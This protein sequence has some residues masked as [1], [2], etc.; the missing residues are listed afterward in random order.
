MPAPPGKA[1]PLPSLESK[2]LKH[3]LLRFALFGIACILPL[4]AIAWQVGDDSG[5]TEVHPM[6]QDLL[7]AVKDRPDHS[8]SWRMLGKIYCQQG[9]HEKAVEAINRA[10]NLMPDNAAAHFDLGELSAKLNRLEDRDFHYRK[11]LE[12]AP[13]TEY[14]QRVTDSGFETWLSTVNRPPTDWQVDDMPFDFG[15]SFVTGEPSDSV[16]QVSYE[17]Q[18]FDGADDLQRRLEQL[19]AS[20]DPTASRWRFSGE[21]GVLYNSNVT[22]TPISREL[23]RVDAASVQWIANTELEWTAVR[24]NAWRFGPLSRGYFTVNESQLADLNLASYQ[25]GIFLERDVNFHDQQWIMRSDYVYS[26][27]QFGGSK[28]GDRH[29]LNASLT[30]IGSDNAVTFGWFNIGVTQFIND[31]LVPSVT[32]Q[33]G[34]AYALGISR[35]HFLSWYQLSGYSYGLDMESADTEGDDYRFYSLRTHGGMDFDL[36]E[37]LNMAWSGG[38]GFRSYPDFR[39]LVSR[40]ELTW[41]AA[42][43]LDYLLRPGITCS[44]TANYDDFVSDNIN[45]DVDRF[46]AGILTTLRYW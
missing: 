17:V 16:K 46:T 28:L 42:A 34:P 36:T 5:L 35:F 45:F 3:C 19:P 13:G 26:I 12:L 31:G 15:D 21:T 44:L 38:L 14:A 22:L 27:D 11:V 20:I 2:R 7:Q 33:D 40:D 8:E 23:A 4:S 6:L 29:E 18:T 32:S 30:H 9:N 10:L 43:R 41:R 39:G 25:G 37:K 24:R 1:C